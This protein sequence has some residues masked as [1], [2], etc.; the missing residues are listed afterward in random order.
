MTALNFQD[1]YIGRITE[2]DQDGNQFWVR[3]A[4]PFEVAGTN[5]LMRASPAGQQFSRGDGRRPGNRCRAT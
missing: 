1:Y 4:K 5:W 2:T 3:F